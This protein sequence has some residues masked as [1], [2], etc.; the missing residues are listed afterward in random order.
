VCSTRTTHRLPDSHATERFIYHHPYDRAFDVEPFWFVSEDSVAAGNSNTAAGTDDLASRRITIM[1]QATLDRAQNRLEMIA[2]IWQGP[3]S[4]AL[5]INDE[6]EVLALKALLANT[7]VV[8]QH[9]T[10]HLVRRSGHSSA[11]PA[12]FYP[13]NFLRNVALQYVMTEWTFVMDIDLTPNGCH[14]MYAS[15]MEVLGE[16][17]PLEQSTQCPGLYAFVLPALEL[18]GGIEF[19]QLPGKPDWR[20]RRCEFVSKQQAVKAI[21]SAALVPMHMYFAPAYMPTNY[22]AW[23][24]RNEIYQVPYSVRFEPYYI[25]RSSMPRFNDSFVNRGGN[26]AQQVYHLWAA[27]YQFFVLPRLFVLDIPHS[28]SKQTPF[29]AKSIDLWHN[30]THDLSLAYGVPVRAAK[31]PEYE[32]LKRTLSTEVSY[33]SQFSGDAAA[34]KADHQV[35]PRTTLLALT[36]NLSL[37]I[38]HC[39]SRTNNLALSLLVC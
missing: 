23:I 32:R 21:R 33:F 8:R 37:S 1:T 26:Y 35:C 11:D 4:L 29:F 16:M 36:V 38:S 15:W 25:A 28:V 7:P 22:S 2:T 9:T 30:F 10:I 13:I 3:I 31:G 27:G 12:A 24:E 6:S 19:E 14:S 39:Q 18:N 34:I 17:L 20:S 5:L